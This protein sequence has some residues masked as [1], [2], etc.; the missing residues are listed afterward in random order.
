MW[1]EIGVVY[2]NDVLVK[3]L[4]I[5]NFELYLWLYDGCFVVEDDYGLGFVEC[6]LYGFELVVI[7]CDV[8]Y[9]GGCENVYVVGEEG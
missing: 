3:Y 9:I 4:G 5:V 6:C 1:F 2:G 8:V 7:V